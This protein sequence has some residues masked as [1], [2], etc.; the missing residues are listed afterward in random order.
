MLRVVLQTGD[1]LLHL[2]PF[3]ANLVDGNKQWKPV[4][5]KHFTALVIENT[6]RAL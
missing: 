6:K 5:H 1:E 2:L 4:G 3:I